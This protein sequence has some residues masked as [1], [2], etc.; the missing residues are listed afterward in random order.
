MM[1]YGRWVFISILSVA[2]IL[3]MN[4]SCFAKLAAGQ[5]A[6]AFALTDTN[7]KSHNLSQMQS[8]AMITLYFFDIDSKAS[9]EGL[10]S[11]NG[12]AGQYR[13]ANLT[14]WAITTSPKEKVASFARSS[15]LIFPILLDSGNVSDLYQAQSILPT[16]C[17]VGPGLKV[18]DFFQ[19]GGKTTEMM[20]VR[21]AERELQQKQT[22]IAAAIS[23]EVVKKDPQNI[24]AKAVKAHAALKDGDIQQAD[25][26]FQEIAKKGGQGEV[27]GKEGLAAVHMKKGEP[28]KALKLASEVEQKAPERSY[29]NVIKGEVLYAQNKVSEAKNE[30]Q[31]AVRKKE[32]APYQQAIGY[33][34]LG[35]IHAKQGE[36]EAARALYDEAVLIDPFY[37]EGTTNKGMTYEREGKW[38]K[39]LDS[40]REALSVEKNDVFASVLAKKAQEMVDLQNDA[41]KRERVDKLVKELAERYRSQKKA[42]SSQEEDTWTSRP[43]VLTFVDFQEKGGLSER[44]GFSTVLTTQLAD[45]LNASNRV[46]VVERVVIERLLEEL[47]IGSSELADPDTALRL[48]KVLAAKLIGTGSLFFL[49]KA[50]MLSMRLIDTETTSVSMVA[51]REVGSQASMETD[52]NRLNRE[53]LQ[54]IISK[55]PLRGFVVKTSGDR[56]MLNIGAKQGVVLGTR[57]EILEDQEAVEYKGKKLQGSARPIGVIEVTQVDQD[58]SYA[59]VV[60]QQRPFKSDDKIQEKL[61]TAAVGG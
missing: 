34:Q 50:T 43:M 3:T 8:K 16:I 51:N 52:L 31:R 26:V 10:I 32:A 35:R 47:N 55:Y 5:P 6:P 39:A 57:F 49:P 53:I 61:E 19:G 40:Y 60:N 11:L 13:G 36:N 17:I 4:G 46:R 12:L 28:E 1:R 27:I 42:A 18:L 2:A 23:N 58:L 33:N 24:E 48:G 30:Y 41:K 25:Q 20:L 14:V 9:Q 21:V 45:Q 29:P 54:N 38:D 59:K 37:I 44:D 22:K 56:I 7:G 15:G